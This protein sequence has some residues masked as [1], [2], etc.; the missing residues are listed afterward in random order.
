MK[1]QIRTEISQ[2]I[3]A[4]VHYVAKTLGLKVG[5][6]YEMIIQ[7][8]IFNHGLEGSVEDLRNFIEDTAE[9]GAPL[10]SE[11]GKARD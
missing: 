5:E 11:T 6:V 3:N 2:G 10:G 7:T 9:A 1:V 4:Q 8:Y